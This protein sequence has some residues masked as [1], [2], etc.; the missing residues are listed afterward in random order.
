MKENQCKG[1]SSCNGGSGGGCHDNKVVVVR[2]EDCKWWHSEGCAFR[3][4]CIPHLPSAD[5]FCSHGERKEQ[6]TWFNF[7]KIK[8]RFAELKKK[9]TEKGK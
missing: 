7:S 8:Q 6:G 4:D 3:N 1:K 5:D 2:C 9:Y